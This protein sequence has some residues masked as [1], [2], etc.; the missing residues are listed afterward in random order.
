MPSRY[1]RYAYRINV[2]IKGEKQGQC[3]LNTPLRKISK[4]N[5]G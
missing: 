1:Y 4:A 5:D 2:V 3:Q